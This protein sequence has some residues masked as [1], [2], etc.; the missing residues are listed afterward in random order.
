MTHPIVELI[1]SKL[2]GEKFTEVGLAELVSPLRA[3]A[4]DPSAVA[5]VYETMALLGSGPLQAAGEQLTALVVQLLATAP[6]PVPATAQITGREHPFQRFGGR[7][8]K[9]DLS[10]PT[11]AGLIPATSFVVPRRA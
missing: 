6:A 4:T 8:T 11:Q 3:A 10:K 9:I 5:A 7:A 2:S 1:L